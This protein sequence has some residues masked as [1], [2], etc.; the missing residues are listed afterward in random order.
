M[1]DRLEAKQ[2]QPE[3]ALT[4]ACHKETNVRRKQNMQD[5]TLH[6]PQAAVCSTEKYVLVTSKSIKLAT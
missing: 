5:A 2:V 1:L 6:S 3:I 4:T